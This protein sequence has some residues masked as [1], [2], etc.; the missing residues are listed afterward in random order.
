MRKVLL[1]GGLATAVVAVALTVSFAGGGTVTSA[2]TLTV[3]E[4]A[5]N[6]KVIDLARSGDTAGDLLVFHNPIFNEANTEQVG[7]DQGECIRTSVALGAWECHWTT[8]IWGRGSITVEGPFYDTRNNVLAITGG[9]GMYRNARGTMALESRK[10]G[11][12]Y[13]FIFHVIP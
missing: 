3:R 4:H 6:E 10:G 8:T 2:T 1:V 11:A 13:E 7:N 12:E 5:V 9:T